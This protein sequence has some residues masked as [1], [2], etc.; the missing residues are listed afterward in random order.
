[1]RCLMRVPA[2]RVV[3]NT[4]CQRQVAS[5]RASE[6]DI[7]SSS[8][9]YSILRFLLQDSSQQPSQASNFAVVSLAVALLYSREKEPVAAACGPCHSTDRMK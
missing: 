5:R 4:I 2:A 9:P 7:P 3:V 1:M 8:R 6:G